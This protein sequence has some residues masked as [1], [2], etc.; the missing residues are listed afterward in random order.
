MAHTWFFRI[1]GALGVGLITA[2]APASSVYHVHAAAVAKAPVPVLGLTTNWRLELLRSRSMYRIPYTTW[3]AYKAN[4][5]RIFVFTL[6]LTNTGARPASP[7]ADLN[8]IIRVKPQYPTRYISG[9]MTLSPKAKVFHDMMVEAAH[10]FGGV[11]IWQ[12]ARPGQTLIYSLV[13]ATNR[14]DSHYGL[15]NE[16]PYK[17]PVFLADTGL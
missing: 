13:I 15:Y 8:L 2:I 1:V 3:S 17:R 10:E 7:Y 9:F 16:L 11:P 12:T 4:F 14:G 5:Y 6:R